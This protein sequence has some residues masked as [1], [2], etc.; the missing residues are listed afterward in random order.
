[1]DGLS[2]RS[3]SSPLFP[4][5]PL[6]GSCLRG[7][8]SPPLPV[9]VAAPL[10]CAHL[11]A[12]FLLVFPSPFA[13]PCR[14]VTCPSRLQAPCPRAP[15]PLV[16]RSPRGR[17]SLVSA[18]SISPLPAGPCCP[19][20]GAPV[21]PRR[22]RPRTPPPAARFP[23][24][25]AVTAAPSASS[26]ALSRAPLPHGPPARSLSAVRPRLPRLVFV[27]LRLPAACPAFPSGPCCAWCCA[28][29]AVAPSACR[30]SVLAASR[31]CLPPLLAVILVWGAD[32]TYI[33]TSLLAPVAL[34]SLTLW[35]LLPPSA[36]ALRSPPPAPAHSPRLRLGV[37]SA[38][39]ACR[40][41]TWTGKRNDAGIEME[42]GAGA[43][44]AESVPM[45]TC[46]STVTPSAYT[47]EML[48]STEEHLASTQ[49]MQPPRILELLDMS[50]HEL[51]SVDLERALFQP[52]PS[53]V[54][55]QNF[56]PAKTYK[57]P[58]LLRNIDKALCFSLCVRLSSVDLERALFQPYPSEVVFQNFAPAK[59]YKLPLLLRNIDK[60][61]ET[62]E[63][64]IR[65]IGPRAILDFRD[66]LH[67]PDCLVKAS[68]QKTQL[69]RNIGNTEA[70][71][72]LRTHSPFSVTP[73]VGTLGPG[74]SMQVTVDFSPD[75]TGRHSDDLLL[76]YH[77]GG[78]GVALKL[79]EEEN[80]SPDTRAMC[81]TASNRERTL[82]HTFE[83]DVC[84]KPDS[85]A[86]EKTFISLCSEDMEMERFQSE[87]ESNPG[88]VHRLA[89][90]S[91]GFQDRLR[92]AAQ[93]HL[94]ASAHSC[95]A[96]EPM[97]GEIY[98][99]ATAQFTI[100]FKPQ[101]ATVYQH[102][103]Y[104][105]VTGR[106]SRLPLTVQGEGV[107]PKLRV[108]YRVTDMQD[109]LS[110][111]DTT[112]GR[113]F[114]VSPE[115]GVLSPGACQV[116]LVS[117]S[118]CTLGSFC[119]DLLLRVTGQPQPLT[120]TFRGRVIGPTFHFD[121]TELNLGD[122]AYGFPHT[123]SCT[124]FN[125]SLVPLT[126][127]LR[128]PG[129]GAGPASRTSGQQ[130]S[131]L[132]GVNRR[133]GGAPGEPHA[134][135]PT[136]FSL[137][138]AAGAIR[139]MS[140]VTLCS[141]TVLAPPLKVLAPP[142]KVLAP[143]PSP[144]QCV[145]PEVV[146]ETRCLDFNQC[147]LGHRYTHTARLAN[148]SHLPAC[149]GLLD[150]QS[151]ALIK[152]QEVFHGQEVVV[153]PGDLSVARR[154]GRPDHQKP[155][156]MN[157]QDHPP[158]HQDQMNNEVHHN[159]EGSCPPD[160]GDGDHWASS[161]PA[162]QWG[163]LCNLL[164]K[165]PGSQHGTAHIAVFGSTQP[166]LMGDMSPW[167]VE[168]R[169]GELAP[170]GQLELRVVVHLRDTL[171]FQDRLTVC[172]RDSQTYDIPLSCVG[173]GSAIVS[174]RPLNPRLDLGRHFSQAVCQ[175]HF[176]LTNRGRRLHRMYWASPLCPPRAYK[177]RARDENS[178]PPIARTGNRSRL[179]SPK[180]KPVFSLS[181]SRTELFPGQGLIPAGSSVGVPLY[182]LAKAP[183]SQHG[184]AHIAVFGS[185][186]PTLEVLLTC[187]GKGPAVHILPPK[188]DFGEVQVLTD[189]WISGALELWVS[190]SL[191]V[192]MSGCLDVWISGCLVW[193]SGALGLWV[194]GCLDV[195]MS[196]CLDV[197]ISGALELWS[198]GAL[199]LWMS[200]SLELWMSGCLDVWMSG[201]LELWAL[202]LWVSGCLD[203]WSSG[204][205]MSGG[206]DVDESSKGDV[207]GLGVKEVFNVAP[208][209][210]K[211][212]P[213]ESQQVAITFHGGAWARGR[214][215]AQCRVEEGP[216]PF[217]H[218]ARAELL[219]T[220]SGDVGF[221]FTVLLLQ[222]PQGVARGEEGEEGEDG[223]DGAGDR[224]GGG[225]H[226]RVEG[227]RQDQSREPGP[228]REG[229]HGSA[230]PDT[231][232]VLPGQPL[233]FPAR[234]YVEARTEWRLCVSYLPGLPDVFQQ[235]FRLQVDHLP[236]ETITLRG[237]GVFPR[238]CLDLPRHL[239]EESYWAG[240]M[241]AAPGRPVGAESC[242]HPANHTTTTN[243]THP[244]T[245]AAAVGGVESQD[246]RYCAHTVSTAYEELVSMELERQLVRENALA[247]TGSLVDLHHTGC[248]GNKWHKLSRFLLPEYVLDFG[249][250][251]PGQVVTRD[252]R[253][254]NTGPMPVSFSANH[255]PL[256]GTGFSTEFENAKQLPCSETQAFTVT[257]DPQ[258]SKTGEIN[259]TMPI[260][261]VGGPSVPVRL[262]AVVT[263]PALTVSS[264]ELLFDSVQCGMCQQRGGRSNQEKREQ[265]HVA[266][267]PWACSGARGG[268]CEFTAHGLMGSLAT[269]WD[270]L[271]GVLQVP[272]CPE[273]APPPT[274][275]EAP[276]EKQ[277]IT[278]QLLNHEQV[279][280]SWSIA[281]PAK[282]RKKPASE[283]K[284]KRE[285]EKER[286]RGRLEKE[287]QM[288]DAVADVKRPSPAPS[289]AAGEDEPRPVVVVAVPHLVLSGTRGGHATTQELLTSGALPP[290]EEVLDGLGLGPSGPPIP[291]PVTFSVVPFPG[292]SPGAGGP[293]GLSE[294]FFFLEPSAPDDSAKDVKDEDAPPVNSGTATKE[295]E[296]EKEKE[297]ERKD[298]ES[299]QERRRRSS[300]KRGRKGS[301]T[302]RSPP[303]T[304][305]KEMWDGGFTEYI[306]DWWNLMD[307]A[308]NSLERDERGGEE[309]VEVEEKEEGEEE[310]KEED[311]EVEVEEEEEGEEEEKEEEEGEGGGRRRRRRWEK[312]RGELAV[313]HLGDC[314][315]GRPRR[316]HFT[317][318]N[319]S[320][321]TAWRFEWPA[322]TAHLSFSPRVG[323]LH[324]GCSK[325]V[326]VSFSSPQ[327][328]SLAAQ[329]VAASLAQVA[330]DRPIEEVADWD[331]RQRT[332]QWVPAAPGPPQ[333]PTA[334]NKVVKAEPEPPCRVVEGSQRDL[335]LRVS[336]VCDYA[337]FSWDSDDDG[338]VR[339]RDTVLYQSRVHRLQMVNQGVVQLEYSWQ[340]FLDADHHHHGVNAAAAVTPGS[341][342]QT[343]GGASVST[344]RPSS[345]LAG[346][347]R[348][349]L[350]DPELPPFSVE[351]GA[352]F[353]GPGA[354]QTI[355]NLQEDVH[356]PSV[357][358]CGRS[359]LPHVHFQLS[360]SD[361]IS[362]RR[363]TPTPLDP[364][365]RVV[366][367]HSVGLGLATP[368]SRRF[369]VVNPT[370]N[371]YSFRW[372]CQDQGPC[373]FRCLTP[374]GTILPG[375]KVEVCL[376][377]ASEQPGAVESGWSFLVEALSLSVPFLL[378][379]TSREPQVY[380][381]TAH[382]DLGDVLVGHRT[383][384][385]VHLVNGEQ[386][387][388][389]F[390][391]LQALPL[392]LCVAVS[393]EGSAR[394]R[395]ALR[396]RG[397]SQ[398]LALSVRAH[399]Y[400]TSA[401]LRLS[402][403][404]GEVD[405]RREVHAG[406]QPHSLDFGEVDL[407]ETSTI[408]FQMSNMGRFSM[409]VTFDLA[410][411]PE[412]LQHLKV[413]PGQEA[414][415]DVSQ[416]LDASLSFCPHGKC[417]LRGVMLHVKVRAALVE[418]R[419]PSRVWL[420]YSCG[421]GVPSS[422]HFS[423][424]K[425]DFG[426]CFLHSPGEV[427][428]SRTLLISN[429]RDRPI[430]VQ[431]PFAD[432]N[433]PHLELDFQADTL[434]PGGVVEA[435]LTF[436][437]GEARRYQDKITFVVGRCA[438]QAVEVLGQGVEMKLEVE[439]PSLQE[440]D[441]GS[442][443]PGQRVKKQVYVVNRTHADLTFST[444]L[445]TQPP[446]DH[447]ELSVSPAGEVTLR[448]L[449]GR[450]ALELLWAPRR[451]SPPFVAQLRAECMGAVR[452]LLTA[453]GSCQCVE[454]QLEPDHL[455]FGAVVQ[456]CAATKRA[457][458]SNSGD[459]GAGPGT[460]RC[461]GTL[462][463]A[464]V[465]SAAR[466]TGAARGFSSRTL[467]TA[468]CR[469]TAISSSGPSP[470]PAA[471]VRGAAKLSRK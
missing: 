446:L 55:F 456:R 102:M 252:V 271:Q 465:H 145:A 12:L 300:S 224:R 25:L 326:S 292:E 13:L 425:H 234:G 323:H 398:P 408:A 182:L 459:L 42:A 128:V 381:D 293:G 110:C 69:V 402:G 375:K 387:S 420:W 141:N 377:Y 132:T 376:E 88:E 31:F 190:G 301:D 322:P 142:L 290:L 172:I 461:R 193:S 50:V 163:F 4:R 423:F 296:K 386:C 218:V 156:S 95:I 417:S 164:A 401:R 416:Q 367:F 427:P 342:P 288:S 63:V 256:V 371:P 263:V 435:R 81:T 208:L 382:L 421:G 35:A 240:W 84:L 130:V 217:H 346:L 394:F 112:F 127:A 75:T 176:R 6:S 339:F 7:L 437:P 431:C 380:L 379:G 233:V 318:T 291:P 370:S 354:S 115:E 457:V 194:S 43:G 307:F 450:C 19:V 391:V 363:P 129:D 361:Y 26:S 151:P 54:V 259:V 390:S 395:P 49:E 442:L 464:H 403:P 207:S 80:G 56:A 316:E 432:T 284:T 250:V 93:D 137:E 133:G 268:S 336:A 280:C 392:S 179:S 294:H 266:G 454:V 200:G 210:G 118:S 286:E 53:E 183:G 213:A 212:A 33:R 113:C 223:E 384:R 332:V 22:G 173:V 366:E 86:L 447:R 178:L 378:V 46:L 195:W 73:S 419:S 314:Q 438:K 276:P 264:E 116:L 303:H 83:L 351:P 320:A 131:Q 136:E 405:C 143:P 412:L 327:P 469:T 228:D 167:R 10:P 78:A 37:A 232:E 239:P 397:R 452:P 152:L 203:V 306:H 160:N 242:L 356:A 184:T 1:M 235:S 29:P 77:T 38:E 400:V 82:L 462:T 150:Q 325:E 281:E 139:A 471:A 117:F 204:V 87:C 225:G 426:K 125:T 79:M 91:R 329:R 347:A 126:Y 211:L 409:G 51:S 124:L 359:L 365:T 2:P 245:T 430:S 249:F 441:L 374:S 89:I 272:L 444:Q 309:E 434:P 135:R 202:G 147:F 24:L 415:V 333:Q 467:A 108:D 383:E 120:L 45:E 257:F 349:L 393:G 70:K 47:Q 201:A 289:Q 463:S 241:G 214:A 230:E 278:I 308:M 310:K 255:K 285:R 27:L 428:A 313:L 404:G 155:L 302:S 331:D 17:L 357:S 269:H 373:A 312:R 209:K 28:S 40:D 180:E 388:L 260:K 338:A 411:P 52:Y 154:A 350:G 66:E 197:W 107:G 68:T 279:P 341:R 369:G 146:V 166:T 192:W 144:P 262:C 103:L 158:S 98:P 153:H 222:D 48:Q 149:Y 23:S 468:V 198:S 297:R 247:V 422:L 100:V 274:P 460:V 105:D 134:P 227:L 258:A 41:V 433:T 104:C 348:L 106:T 188:L 396:V 114:S 185:T 71:F 334:H 157:L 261:V 58:L 413:T 299:Q 330:F 311:V 216:V 189:L 453:R 407:R 44:G 32:A 67:L 122:V 436:R 355:P 254:T 418:L 60:A 237:E 65:A 275:E 186:Q 148:I 181:P 220:N 298:R 399:G 424:T 466:E 445:Y 385:T 16:F 162:P 265:S 246:N 458:L 440:V 59:T 174:D 205:W 159:N 34:A 360:D 74:E 343:P 20:V 238:I 165:A 317:V 109:V 414:T 229:H 448:A 236:P 273:D 345:A 304:S 140:D 85:V 123:L 18:W 353:L 36:G 368:T 219:L 215:V 443:L 14:P 11:L 97:E 470:S 5:G 99:N 111:P 8:R 64:P 429:T 92:R 15:W 94:A 451:R 21:P 337:K 169:E 57:L 324:A 170:E 340:V 449:G 372:V 96:I 315:V 101:E 39:L 270:R 389:H 283:R 295:K 253:I 177:R 358:V 226:R 76:H 3:L 287:R 187:V 364:R 196:G 455:A 171:R 410:G 9:W 199:G 175:Y 119:E 138:P 206:L 161:L 277:V 319:H 231:E 90:L 352:G 191:D 121:I 305:I 251:I 30:A 168:P 62:F 248:S 243:T 61:L 321:D 221:E 328:A 344:A 267:D 335:E 72:Q 406:E 362:G 282:P 244:T 439:D